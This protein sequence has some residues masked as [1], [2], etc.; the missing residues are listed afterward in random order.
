MEKEEGL[1]TGKGKA[2]L[3]YENGKRKYVFLS[4]RNSEE[5][6]KKTQNCFLIKELAMQ[7]CLLY[8]DFQWHNKP[9]HLIFNTLFS[10]QPHR[11][12]YLYLADN[13]TKKQKH[14]SGP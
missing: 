6:V 9:I 11:E 7:F 3:I 1:Y 10:K 4:L 14:Y 13:K 8:G 12:I 2:T 5:L